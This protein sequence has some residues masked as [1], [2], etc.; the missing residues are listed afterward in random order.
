MGNAKSKSNAEGVIPLIGL[1]ERVGKNLRPIML[2]ER[3]W[4]ERVNIHI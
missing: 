4:D 2:L 3:R 1:V